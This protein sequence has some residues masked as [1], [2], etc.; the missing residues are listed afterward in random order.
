MLFSRRVI[1]VNKGVSLVELLLIITAVGFLVLIIGNIPNSIGLIGKA[2]RQSIAREIASKQIE[3][4]R[5]ISYANLANGTVEVVDSRLV[6]LPFGSGQ[7][8]IS[9]CNPIV[10]NNSEVAKVLEVEISWKELT[11]M[12]TL[13]INTLI[14]QGGL[15]Q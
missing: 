12:E 15:N 13:K 10:C 7:V 14:S 11:D 6:S 9:D 2:G 4:K 5:A 3:D 8:T 1:L